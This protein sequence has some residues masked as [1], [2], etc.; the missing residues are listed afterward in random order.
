MIQKKSYYLHLALARSGHN[1]R[2][3]L[4]RQEGEVAERWVVAGGSL[5]DWFGLIF[6]KPDC[7]PEQSFPCQP[8]KSLFDCL[9]H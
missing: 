2:K 5:Y 9:S 4:C 1:S 8:R 3:R 7:L 6:R